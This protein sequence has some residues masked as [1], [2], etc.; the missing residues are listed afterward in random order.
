V[1]IAWLPPV[2]AQRAAARGRTIPIAL[3]IRG[4]TSSFHSA[5][6][7]RAGSRLR[8]SQD[9]ERVR[10]AWV[11]RQSAAGYLVIRAQIRAQGVNLERAFASEVFLGS[12]EAVVKA[13]SAG[14][15][16]VG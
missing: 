9:L 7:T 8:S 16:D 1:D 2:I 11:D 4:G 12:H 10:A 3:P 6:F 13:V 15:V 14:D 5:L